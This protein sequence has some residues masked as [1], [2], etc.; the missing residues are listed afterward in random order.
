MLCVVDQFNQSRSLLMWSCIMLLQYAAVES[1]ICSLLDIWPHLRKTPC[2]QAM[3][4]FAICT[5]KFAV[6]LSM[7]TQVTSHSH[8]F[9]ARMFLLTTNVAIDR[10]LWVFPFSSLLC[11]ES[12]CFH[13]RNKLWFHTNDPNV[14]TCATRFRRLFRS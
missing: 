9:C 13:A 11:A 14:V 10:Y 4:T 8:S 2:R 5:L 1:F 12:I 6:G 3:F 7:V